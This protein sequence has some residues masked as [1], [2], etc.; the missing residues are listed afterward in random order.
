MT[1]AVKDAA[2]AVEDSRVFRTL[3][4]GGYAA[5]GLVHL[6]IGLVVLIIAGGG[7]GQSDQ[8]GAFAILGDSVLGLP[9][10]WAAAI[11]LAALGVWH[12]FE[13]IRVRRRSDVKKWGVRIGEA[14]QAVVFLALGA[15]AVAVAFGA[16][17]DGDEAAREASSGALAVP[18][19]VFLL[20]AVGLGLLIGG[21]SFVVMGVRRT[22]R[23]KVAVP[24]GRWGRIV[25]IA[26]IVGFVAKGVALA[27]IGVL[28]LVAAVREEARA[29]GGLDAAVEAL[30]EMPAGPYLVGAVGAGL[31]VYGVFTVA[32][33]KYAKL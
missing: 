5:N 30:L 32:R 14:G 24:G 6:L 18:G 12:A 19:G 3:A 8:A 21:V 10:L 15:V 20:G 17:P 7:D 1:D 28:L 9:V 23:N 26:G 27:V 13:A 4:R 11:L 33:A 22:F 16:R 29:A 2:A 25:T 31:I